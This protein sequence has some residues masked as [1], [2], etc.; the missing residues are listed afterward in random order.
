MR[1]YV[2]VALLMVG[3]STSR[4]K[5]ICAIDCTHGSTLT[6]DPVNCKNYYICYSPYDHSDFPFVCEDYRNCTNFYLCV[7]TGFPDQNTHGHCPS[8]K[9]ITNAQQQYDIAPQTLPPKAIL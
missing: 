6:A 9:P 1:A 5:D 8:A 2:V 7:D 3:I 4:G